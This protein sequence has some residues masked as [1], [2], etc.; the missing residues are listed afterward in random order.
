M[1]EEAD[2][3]FAKDDS[4]EIT[5]HLQ[6]LFQFF[7]VSCALKPIKIDSHSE[8][9]FFFLFS[10]IPPSEITATFLHSNKR[11]DTNE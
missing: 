6:K 11:G 4:K 8:K 1:V 7:A 3:R 10:V 2:K 9:H 5:F